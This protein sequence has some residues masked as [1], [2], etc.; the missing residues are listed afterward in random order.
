MPGKAKRGAEGAAHQNA[1]L[2][3][4]DEGACH[5]I[6]TLVARTGLERHPTIRAAGALVVRGVAERAAM[7][8]Y[9]LTPAGVA[10]K[11]SGKPITK[12][13]RTYHA[14]S[15]RH[16][17]SLRVRLWRAIR[18]KKED[19]FTSAD[20]VRL[21]ARDE[22]D[23]N[24]LAAGAREYLSFLVRSG[25]LLRL[26]KRTRREG[27]TSFARYRLTLNTGPEAPMVA[28]DRKSLRDPNTGVVHAFDAD[29]AP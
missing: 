26:A 1:V 19:A 3:A 8:C 5:D 12:G 22:E 27:K 7:G 29:A 13:P 4:L 9:R 15:R 24:K 14:T 21:V 18:V 28:G 16:P 11:A 25:H 10:Q 6:D 17:A 20:L 23:L 2:A